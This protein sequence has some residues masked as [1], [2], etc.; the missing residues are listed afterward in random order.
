MVAQE[1]VSRHALATSRR[2]GFGRGDGM[3]SV[4][5][6]DSRA[7]SAVHGLHLEGVP[8][9][10][11]GV[12]FDRER[13]ADLDGVMSFAGTVMQLDDGRFRMY[14]SCRQR[15]PSVFRVAVAESADGFHWDRPQ[16]GQLDWEGE[17]TNH[18]QIGGLLRGA[19]IIQPQVVR[20]PGGRWLMYCWL[21]EHDRGHIRY[22][23]SESDDGLNWRLT[24]LD[25]P[26]VYHPADRE[27]GQSGWVAG[28][29]QASPDDRFAAER[30]LDWMEAKRLRSNDATYV[31]YDA[32]RRLFEMYSVW[33]LPNSPATHRHTP[34]DNAP[35]VLRAIHHRT[36]EDGLRWSAPE[37][38]IVPD[39]H[40]PLDQQFYYLAVHRQQDWRLGF[41]GH[42]RC[43]EQTMD[44]ELCFS[45]DGRDWLRPL[46][47]GWIPRDPLPELGCMSVYATS[48]VL[49][50]G[51]EQLMLYTAGNTKHNSQLPPG[52]EHPWR[53]VMAATWPK[54]RFAGLAT[55]PN[56]LGSLAL[57]P[58]IPQCPKITVDADIRGWLRAELRDPFGMPI[59]GF[60]LAD[61]M[62]VTGNS[63]S[64]V[65]RWQ[66]GATT[67]PYQYD[68]V[69]LRLEITAGVVYAVGM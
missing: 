8:V 11:H 18:L 64:H 41:L 43:W 30:K 61:S 4:S 9:T 21:H 16:F 29:T 69:S 63:R 31:Y 2:G 44:V 7:L 6:Y 47:G 68:A 39:E 55:S 52:V 46:R 53:G 60:Q 32:E 14:Y 50:L 62:P 59:D 23:I 26:A 22:L 45:R 34:R 42:Y 65:L 58:F 57:K 66:D 17:D 3:S 36:S 1:N 28:L 5:F 56:T 33:L 15:K 54:G 24:D 51:D 49:D 20:G 12:V 67:A 27:V 37:L 35:Q 48:D 10:K 13:P 25:R 19:N 40:D 38:L